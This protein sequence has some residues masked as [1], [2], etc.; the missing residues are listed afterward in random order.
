MVVLFTDLESS[1]GT[2]YR[3]VLFSQLPVYSQQ[4]IAGERKRLEMRFDQVFGTE[5]GYWALDQRIALTWANKASLIMVLD[6]PEIPLH[7]NSAEL[8][9]RHRFVKF[10]WV[11][12]SP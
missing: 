1:F 5:T 3:P 7:N 8:D 4:P 6:Y 2:A 11:E 9:A 12:P 10:S